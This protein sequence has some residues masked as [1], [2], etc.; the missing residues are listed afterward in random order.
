MAL[1][2]EFLGQLT[3]SYGSVSHQLTSHICICGGH[4]QGG[5]GRLQFYLHTLRWQSKCGGG[6]DGGGED[7]LHAELFGEI[8]GDDGSWKNST[9]VVGVVVGVGA[10]LIYNEMI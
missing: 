2:S 8:V 7:G 3:L 6:G 4:L 1:V 9:A 10:A 5:R